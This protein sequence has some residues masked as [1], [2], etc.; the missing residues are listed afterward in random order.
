MKKSILFFCI[1]F[2]NCKTK[3][4]IIDLENKENLKKTIPIEIESVVKYKQD[5]AY[6]LGFRLINACNISKFKNYTINEAVQKVR[7]NITEKKISETCKKIAIRNGK[8]LKMSLS[9]AFFNENSNE[10]IFIYELYFE[11]TYFKRQ[12]QVTINQDNLLTSIITKEIKPK[13][14]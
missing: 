9:K 5:K 12:L 2:I 14:L 8:F 3:N 1:I 4:N 6:Q 11:K 7:E 13:P 10:T